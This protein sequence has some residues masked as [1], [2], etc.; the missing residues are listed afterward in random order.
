MWVCVGHSG[1]GF[2]VVG[3]Y[4][5]GEQWVSE[6]RLPWICMALVGSLAPALLP[7]PDRLG[8]VCLPPCWAGP[9]PPRQPHSHVP[10]SSK[11]KEAG[12]QV[13][14]GASSGKEEGAGEAAAGC[15]RAAEQQEAPQERYP[16]STPRL[17]GSG[18]RQRVQGLLSPGLEVPEAP[19]LCL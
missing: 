8:R 17:W 5:G 4:L 2:S 18:P 16:G 14:G 13:K 12:S 3:G 15:E 19:F 1:N 9:W 6:H 11:W 7:W 10:Y